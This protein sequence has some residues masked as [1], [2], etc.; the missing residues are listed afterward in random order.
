LLPLVALCKRHRDTL[1]R[2]RDHLR[3][4]MIEDLDRVIGRGREQLARSP[5]Y[6]SN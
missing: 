2:E 4:A 5:D 6:S 1:R 3:A